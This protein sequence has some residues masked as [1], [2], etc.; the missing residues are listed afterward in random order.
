MS[1]NTS[2]SLS[3]P[4]LI[5]DGSSDEDNKAISKLEWELASQ[6]G[7]IRISFKTPV[8][9]VHYYTYYFNCEMQSCQNLRHFQ[10]IQLFQAM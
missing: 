1:C 2:S 6:T 5:A 3:N 4:D 9:S 8:D 10:L 7:K